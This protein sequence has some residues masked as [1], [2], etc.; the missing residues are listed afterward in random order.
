MYLNGIFDHSGSTRWQCFPGADRTGPAV[1]ESGHQRA[2]QGLAAEPRCWLP[3]NCDA[4]GS[5]FAPSS[6]PPRL[7]LA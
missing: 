6:R 4:T 7:F 5:Q 2:T 3:S 1:Q